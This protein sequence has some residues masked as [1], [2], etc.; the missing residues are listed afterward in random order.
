MGTKGHSMRAIVHGSG[1]GLPTSVIVALFACGCLPSHRDI[2]AQVPL[3]GPN[4]PAAAAP[5]EKGAVYVLQKDAWLSGLNRT[6]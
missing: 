2:T 6:R 3:D 5:Y 1:S 4:R